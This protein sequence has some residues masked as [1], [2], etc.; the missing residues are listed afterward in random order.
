[1]T[2]QDLSN[3][4][5]SIALRDRLLES[6]PVAARRVEL[7]GISTSILEGGDGPP[8]VLLHGQG[9][10]ASTS[11]LRVIPRL[12][13]T[14]HVI[15]PDLPGLGES[16]VQEGDLNRNRVMAWTAELIQKTCDE[17]P[18]LVGL[19]LGG[20]IA[21]NFASDQGA[22]LQQIVLVDSGSLGKFRPAPGVL[23]AL[24]RSSVRPSQRNFDRFARQVFFDADRVRAAAGE[25]GLLFDA[26]A[27]NRASTP[28]LQSANR[29][30][31]RSLGTRAISDANLRRISVPVAMIWGRHDRVIRLG[32]AESAQA[33]FG[34]SLYVLDE[35]GH[36]TPVEQPDA[37]VD[38]L[39]TAIAAM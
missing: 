28:G 25:R 13:A 27:L 23:I 30:L 17:P 38:A 26:Y 32:V 9:P 15:A 11:W 8:M 20:S 18:T 3:S 16:A 2:R 12:V 33:K 31:L 29:Q 22:Y 19:S 21:A 14:H 24:I 34:W 7:A 35:C 10:Y 36:V 37:F 6:L 4:S 5:S 1:M 39:E